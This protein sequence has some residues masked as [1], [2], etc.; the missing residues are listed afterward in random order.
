VEGDP[1]ERI[2]PE[3]DPAEETY[4]A[5][6]A[7]WG[8]EGAKVRVYRVTPQG[9]QYCFLGTPE[10]IDPESLRMFHAKQ[11]YS[12]ETGSYLIEVEVNGEVRSPFPILIAP[13]TNA[14]GVP[15]ASR[16]DSAMTEMFRML[17]AQ[18]ERLEKQLASQNREP[19]GSLADAL[20]K[21]D[22]LRGGSKAEVPVDTLLK[23]I[24]LGKEM[25]G[26]GETDW[27]MKLLDVLKDSMPAL[28]G[29]VGSLA[30]RIAPTDNNGGGDVPVVNDDLMLKQGLIYLKKKA[31]AGSDPG[32]YVDIIV[33]NREEQLYEKL[34]RR[35]LETDFSA[36]AAIDADISRPEY[37]S[38]F[39]AI[40][41]GVRSVFIQPSDV[42]V[43]SVRQ[44]GD[45]N[46]APGDGKPRKAGGKKS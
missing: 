39:R 32:L 16:N 12:H 38:F 10:E 43:D 8:R 23:A 25:G 4:A 2:L 13:Q 45:D 19:I 7:K 30:K 22:Q 17:Q 20:L 21:I 34:I 3:S 26:G 1:E 27:T 31:L 6:M 37:E 14:P 40:Y 36:F 44:A 29:I 35:I 9:K 5:F 15:E 24:Q 11:S 33:D 42:E 46:H 41:N 18:N 28:Q